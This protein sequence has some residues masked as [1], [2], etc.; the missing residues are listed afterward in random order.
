MSRQLW[1]EEI[2]SN[3]GING[4]AN[5]SGAEAIM[6]PDFVAPA[7]FM[8]NGK[9]LAIWAL[10]KYSNVVTT[11]GSITFRLR[12]GGVAGTILAQTSAIAL[13]IVAQTDVMGELTLLVEGQDNGGAGVGAI[14]AMGRVTLAAELAGSNNAPDFM[15]SAGGA[16]GNTPAQV[17]VDLTTQ[18]NL[19]LT[20]ASTVATGS[21]TG[22]LYSI[23]ALS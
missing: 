3:Y 19:S 8:Q 2:W 9:R 6:F 5:T 4:V 13:N 17:L 7:N 14:L 21:C 12:W 1:A 11:P 16:S 15:G 18:Q 22:M 20:Y 10:F 23:V